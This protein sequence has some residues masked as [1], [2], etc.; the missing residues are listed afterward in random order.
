M[1]V[2][3]PNFC[4]SPDIDF[5]IAGYNPDGSPDTTFGGGTGRVPTDFYGNHDE[6]ENVVLQPDGKI[7]V[8]GWAFLQGSGVSLAVA[9]YNPDGSLDTTFGGGSGKALTPPLYF[10]LGSQ[11]SQFS[12]TARY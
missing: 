1:A 4:C 5:R 8:A 2:G 9:R 7:I 12:P 3:D 11:M 6:S 10:G